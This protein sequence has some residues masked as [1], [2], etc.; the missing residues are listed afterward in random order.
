[1]DGPFFVQ[2]ESSLT[3]AAWQAFRSVR[4]AATCSAEGAELPNV[5][6]GRHVGSTLRLELARVRTPDPAAALRECD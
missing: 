1:M 2:S 4:F 5:F 6:N 3:T